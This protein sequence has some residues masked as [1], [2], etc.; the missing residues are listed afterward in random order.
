MMYVHQLLGWVMDFVMMGLI[1]IMEIKY[2]LIV[3]NLTMMKEIV[4]GKQEQYQDLIQMEELKSPINTEVCDDCHG[5]GMIG[6]TDCS[7]C[8]GRG[9]I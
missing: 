3:R 2:I 5:S 4:M 8:N 1:H 9:M 6:D 7:S